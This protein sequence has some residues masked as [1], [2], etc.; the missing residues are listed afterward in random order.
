ML[1]G[2][3]ADAPLSRRKAGLT[4]RHGPWTWLRL[5]KELDE[6]YWEHGDNGLGSK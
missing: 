3:A 5:G 4:D 6:N 1:R 2:A